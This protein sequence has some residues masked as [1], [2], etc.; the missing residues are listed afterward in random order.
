VFAVKVYLFNPKSSTLNLE[1][2]LYEKISHQDLNFFRVK[3]SFG[4]SEFS[5]EK[6]TFILSTNQRVL[7]VIFACP[8]L[9]SS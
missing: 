9:K 2:A 1:L 7:P 4:Y 3:E 5:F 6:S 8:F